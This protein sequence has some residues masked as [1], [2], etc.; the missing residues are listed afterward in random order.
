MSA[1][2]EAI[3][4]KLAA[5]ERAGMDMKSPRAVVDFLLSQGE[6][7]SILY[8]YKPRS[9][10]FDFEKFHAAVEEMQQGKR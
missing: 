2:P 5:A 4:E 1:T 7:A 6:K 9:V 3:L 10:E 8:F